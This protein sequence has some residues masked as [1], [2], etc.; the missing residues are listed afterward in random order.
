MK[1]INR[2][3]IFI[4]TLLSLPRFLLSDPVHRFGGRLHLVVPRADHPA[5]AQPTEPLLHL[6][7]RAP[8][9]RRRRPRP[10]L[11]TGFRHHGQRRGRVG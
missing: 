2:L 11:G 10:L 9:V 6:P 5:Q 3:K 7:S 4:A 8:T 1:S